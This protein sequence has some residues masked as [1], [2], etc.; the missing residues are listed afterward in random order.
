[1]N[2]EKFLRKAL[3]PDDGMK[4]MKL[5]WATFEVEVVC[6]KCLRVFIIT[7]FAI[8]LQEKDGHEALA[9]ILWPTVNKPFICQECGPERKVDENNLHEAM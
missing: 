1:M 2:K 8:Y 4:N 7:P 5:K 3:L 9:Q 6:M